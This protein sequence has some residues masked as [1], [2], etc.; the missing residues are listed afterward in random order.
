MPNY[1]I[2]FANRSQSVQDWTTTY[3]GHFQLNPDFVRSGNININNNYT[4]QIAVSTDGGI[5]ATNLIYT[6]ATQL[7]SIQ[8]H[9]PN[10]WEL[11]Q[12]NGI[13]TLRC[14]LED[15]PEDE[16]GPVYELLDE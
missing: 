14:L 7:W 3:F 1:T 11:A 9:T 2:R 4:F 6:S 13:V 15:V 5:A 12:G 10:E 8:T 16:N